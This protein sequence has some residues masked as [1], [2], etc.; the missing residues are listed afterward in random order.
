MN[1]P[2]VTLRGLKPWFGCLLKVI[3]LS[4]GHK[5]PRIKTT[6]VSMSHLDHPSCTP[7]EAINMIKWEIKRL[8]LA[9]NLTQMVKERSPTKKLGKDLH[10]SEGLIWNQLR[11]GRTQATLVMTTLHGKWMELQLIATSDRTH[12]YSILIYFEGTQ[13][14]GYKIKMEGNYLGLNIRSPTKKSKNDTAMLIQVDG[15]Q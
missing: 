2:F 14:R 12:W 4:Y 7:I 11:S 5:R 8:W 10:E 15:F 6:H 9:F 3:C 1:L 13:L